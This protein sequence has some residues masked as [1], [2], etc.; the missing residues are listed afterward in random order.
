[1]P[2]ASRKGF[3]ATR[4]DALFERFLRSRR[5]GDELPQGTAGIRRS[6]QSRLDERV[7]PCKPSRRISAWRRR[8]PLATVPTPASNPAEVAAIR[9][10]K[11][12]KSLRRRAQFLWLKSIIAGGLSSGIVTI[13]LHPLETVKVLLQKE[14][15]GQSMREVF[16][17]LATHGGEKTEPRT[18][19]VLQGL[20]S[21]SVTSALSAMPSAAIKMG[22][23]E[24]C[25]LAGAPAW[26]A[27]SFGMVVSASARAPFELAK[28][29]LQ[30]G[31]NT[32]TW[33]ACRDLLRSQGIGGL[34]RGNLATIIRDLPYF[35][36]SVS[37]YE[38]LKR[39]IAERRAR[40]KGRQLGG[41]LKVRLR[42]PDPASP[43]DGSDDEIFEYPIKVSY[44]AN[45][46][47]GRPPVEPERVRARN[48]TKRPTEDEKAS[49][50][51]AAGDDENHGV[52]GWW[53]WGHKEV[54]YE[55]QVPPPQNLLEGLLV[56]AAGAASSAFAGALSTPADVVK[57][58]VQTSFR[59]TPGSSV[60]VGTAF[61][62]ILRK[63]GLAAMYRGA[64]QRAMY[65]GILGA[66]Y[67]PLYDLLMSYMSWERMTRSM[68]AM[69]EISRWVTLRPPLRRTTADAVPPAAF[70]C[71]PPLLPR[72]I[73]DLEQQSG[74]SVRSLLRT[75]D[76]FMRRDTDA[77]W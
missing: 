67:Y 54:T 14:A 38:Y 40:S 12:G 55:Y 57:T 65:L 72:R 6:R 21:G 3:G 37:V 77:L 2:A 42:I 23:Y 48:D 41:S 36:I 17:F 52:F 13:C 25:R 58:R 46:L 70:C 51:A 24:L 35:A 29:R 44:S 33:S 49:S 69:R 62:L 68:A 1:M 39:Q 47:I 9:S 7:F 60:G 20:Y 45:S 8:R 22:S 28:T 15:K 18:R 30:A 32:N 73:G 27:A 34:Y 10:A 26:F 59:G 50:K 74:A 53:R 63:E 71:P 61:R 19:D 16:Y 56:I 64:A 11:S 31:L 4:Q 43:P 76:G 75:R 5:K 66:L